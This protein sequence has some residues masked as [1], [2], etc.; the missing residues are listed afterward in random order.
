MGQFGSLM[1]FFIH[2]TKVI[3]LLCQMIILLT[4]TYLVAILTCYAYH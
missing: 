2:V 4:L 3:V 1:E